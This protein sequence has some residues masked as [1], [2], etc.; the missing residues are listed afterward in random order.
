MKKFLILLTL[1]LPCLAYGA[2]HDVSIEFITPGIVHVVKGKPTK[3]LVVTAKAGD[4]ALTRQGNTT[5][6]NLLSLCPISNTDCMAA[7]HSMTLRSQI[8]FKKCI[9]LFDFIGS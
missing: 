8:A 7:S 3:S 1:I 5:S 9:Y 2:K 4:V 6:S